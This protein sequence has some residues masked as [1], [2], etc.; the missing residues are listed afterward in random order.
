MLLRPP[1]TRCPVCNY[2]L[3]GIP[4]TH[5]CPECGYEFD[6]ATLIFRPTRR[7]GPISKSALAWIIGIYLLGIPLL[8]PLIATLPPRAMKPAALLL[9]VTFVALIVVSLLPLLGKKRFASIG[10]S[11]LIIRTSG[12]LIELSYDDIS[13]VAL[14]D[15]PPSITRSGGEPISLSHMFDSNS[16]KQQFA[17]VLIAARA[18]SRPDTLATIGNAG[19]APITAR[20]RAAKTQIRLGIAAFVLTSLLMISVI[21]CEDVRR[22]TIP[23]PLKVAIGLLGWTGIILTIRGFWMTDAKNKPPPPPSP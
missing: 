20:Q 14:D 10:P 8:S 17:A 19:P 7:W 2:S 22:I 9:L 6:E 13:T 16:E 1:L 12:P 5:N 3:A 23:S 18:G 4:P 15:L 21:I 11:K